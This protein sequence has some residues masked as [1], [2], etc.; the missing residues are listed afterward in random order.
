MKEYLDCLCRYC[1]FTGRSRRREYWMFAV[2][3]FIFGTAA[4][5][6]DDIL[7]SA[8]A[9]SL[10]YAL[11][12]ML[13][14]TAVFVRRLHDTD[15]SAWWILIMFI[16]LIGSIVILVFLCQNGTIGVNRFG[17][18]PKLTEIA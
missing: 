11:F 14:S 9:V 4:S 10:I 18:D 3:N 5:L 2:M 13:P 8:G 7:G 15:H 12:T 6:M 16:P 1:V 17:D